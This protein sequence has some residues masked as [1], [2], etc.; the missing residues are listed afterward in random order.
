[1]TNWY[2]HTTDIAY[3]V[4]V[5]PNTVR[6]YEEWGLLPPIPRSPS[7]YRLF[8]E[9]HLDQMRLARS[10]MAFTWLGGDIRH[11][12]Y[13][14]LQQAASGDLGGALERAYQVLVLVQSERAQAEGAAS[15]LERWAWGTVTDATLK[16]MRIGEVARYMNVTSDML[17]NW[18]HNG[19]IQIPR[20]PEN[21]YRMYGASEIGRLRVIRVLRRSGY[22]MMA[23]L[24]MLVQLDGGQREGLRQALDTPRSD[25]DIVS[26]TD[27]WL[28][29]LA[30]SEPRVKDTITQLEWMLQKQAASHPISRSQNAQYGGRTIVVRQFSEILEATL[31]SITAVYPGRRLPVVWHS[32]GIIAGCI[33]TCA[34]YQPAGKNEGT[35]RRF[36][37]GVAQLPSSG[38]TRFHP[39]HQDLPGDTSN[40]W[41]RGQHD[42]T[43]DT[44]QC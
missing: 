44:F 4:A 28:S 1:M 12:S 36:C 39:G 29:T 5:H 18:E 16:P 11:E 32:G 42:C 34:G 21:G 19:L 38:K 14:M 27:K 7:G 25:E 23:I 26:A 33:P 22:S 3:A 6:K 41:C 31:D 9:T 40:S 10:A 30:H 37:T 24:R 17:R 35:G 2:L 43:G 15:L 20:N 13:A 8:S